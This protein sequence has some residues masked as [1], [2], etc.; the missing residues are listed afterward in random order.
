MK[1]SMQ[2][3]INIIAMVIDLL[4]LF[5]WS[6]VLAEIIIDIDLILKAWP[7]WHPKWR[8]NFVYF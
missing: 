5:A 3:C 2:N 1:K 7:G 6:L 8:E 4:P